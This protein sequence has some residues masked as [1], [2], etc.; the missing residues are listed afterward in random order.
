MLDEGKDVHTLQ[1]WDGERGVWL[2]P[3]R[4]RDLETQAQTRMETQ[5]ANLLTLLRQHATQ[6]AL[7]PEVPDT[8]AAA[9]QKAQW[10][11]DF[12]EALQVTSGERDWSSLLPPGARGT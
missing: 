2:D 8:L 9:W 3:M 7:A 6:G 11:P 4:A 5:T 10:V 12:A 1:T